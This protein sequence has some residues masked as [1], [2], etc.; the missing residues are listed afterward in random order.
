M[1]YWTLI[2]LTTVVGLILSEA[3]I[4]VPVA[5][6]SAR[7]TLVGLVAVEISCISKI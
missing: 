7:D 6:P 2:L 3:A 1:E 5:V 4:V